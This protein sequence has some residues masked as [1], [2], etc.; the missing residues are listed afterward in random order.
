MT[1]YGLKIA[2][3]FGKQLP[4]FSSQQD[5]EK[6]LLTFRDVRLRRI[7]E[8]AR[9]L[10]RFKPDYTPESLKTMEQLYFKLHQSNSFEKVGSN[11]EEFE[12]CMA[13]YFG[14]VFVR[15]V[16]N[17]KWVVEEFAFERGKYEIGVKKGLFTVMLRR[18][19]DHFKE[20]NNK[21]QESIWRKFTQY[22]TSQCAE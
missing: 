18:F 4:G 9:A 13:I 8:L 21:K 19:T 14:E 1:K 15:N 22:R 11:R 20:P 16:P 6:S 17:S 10:S 3:L 5:A 12:E 7:H 2:G